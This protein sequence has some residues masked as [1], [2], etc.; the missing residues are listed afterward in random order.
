M[1]HMIFRSILSIGVLLG[2]WAQ[3]A[4]ACTET[5]VAQARNAMEITSSPA[6]EG[7]EAIG[8]EH[9]CECPTALQGVQPFVSDSG[10]S[11]LAPYVGEGGAF[12][13]PSNPNSAALAERS[14]ASSFFARLSGRPPYLLV[15][16]LRQ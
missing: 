1:D 10:K 8:G 15:S 12:L 5:H 13:N 4:S 6:S 9:R 14:R 3:S 7:V 2:A 16:H 11:F